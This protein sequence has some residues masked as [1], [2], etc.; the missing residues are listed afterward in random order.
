MT[1]ELSD[2]LQRMIDEHVEH[3]D[4]LILLMKAGITIRS[5]PDD[6]SIEERIT[7][8]DRAI[9]GLKIAKSRI[10]KY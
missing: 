5:H 2:T 8:E 7:R 1:K 9:D 4:R 3:R 10:P 6:E